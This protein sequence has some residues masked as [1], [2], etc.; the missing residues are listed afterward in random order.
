MRNRDAMPQAPAE[1]P[2][3]ANRMEWEISPL[4]RERWTPNLVSAAAATSPTDNTISILDVIGFD[5]WTGEGVTTKRIAAALRT[6]GADKDVVVN[7]NSPG[8][9]VFEGLA[10]YNLLR[11]HKGSVTT[12]VLGLAASAASIVAMAGDEVLIARAGFFMVH[13]AWAVAIGNRLDLRAAADALEPIDAAMADIYAARSG[14]DPKKT[15]KMM[16]AETWINGSSAVDQNFAD[17]LLPADQVKVDTTAKVDRV[18]AHLL[19]M[20]LAKAGLPRG[21]RRN[22]LSEYKAGTHKAAAAATR[23]ASEDDTPSAVGDELK[24]AL[25]SFSIPQ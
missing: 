22:L 14:M 6:I 20:A 13:N 5:P 21:E 9:D 11:D 1:R 25:Q 4:A 17:G 10:I 23:N 2:A 8:G 18:A 19:D 12:R 15:Q 24:A 7:I 3:W 16:D